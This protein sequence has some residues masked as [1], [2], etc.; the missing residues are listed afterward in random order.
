MNQNLRKAI[1]KIQNGSKMRLQSIDL[2]IHK[3]KNRQS[4]P[5]FVYLRITEFIPIWGP[6]YY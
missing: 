1:G 4:S 6:T 3:T 5:L 2:Q